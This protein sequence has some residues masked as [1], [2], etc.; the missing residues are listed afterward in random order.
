MN[1]LYFATIPFFAKPNPSFHLM[2]AMIYDLLNRG[3]HVY[4]VGMKRRDLDKHI[5]MEFERHPNFHCRLVTMGKVAKTHF[6]KRYLSGVFYALKAYK[7]LKEFMPKCDIVFLQSTPTMLY[8]VLIVRAYAKRQKLVMNIQDMFPGSSIASGVMPKKWMQRVFFTL[9]KVAYR[10]VNV[11]VG[12]SEDMRDRIMEQGVPKEKTRVILNWFDD[13][14]V[15]Y[16]GWDNNRYVKKQAMTKD[17]FYVQYAGTMGFVFDYKIVLSVAELLKDYKNIVIQMI[18]MGSQKEL[19]EEEAKGKGLN[20]IQFLPLE[21]QEM[22]SDV[23]SA[24]SVCYIPLKHGIIG[25]SVPSKAGLL[26]ECKRAIVTSVDKESKYARE[27]NENKIGIACPDDNPQAVVDAILYLYE[28]PKECEQMG[29]RGYRYGHNLYSRT[30][31]VNKYVNLFM[32]LIESDRK[33]KN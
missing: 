2:Y 12:I 26:M 9:Q 28:N 19:F 30:N 22:V 32:E 31:N 14:S 16:V 21:P 8:N 13:K 33:V 18:G 27:I 23:Y 15:H 6:V 17:K 3:D 25:N 7:Y 24:C 1:I 20:N 10:K 29:A 11:I 4:Y 5:P